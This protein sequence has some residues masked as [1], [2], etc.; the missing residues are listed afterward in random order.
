MPAG[1]ARTPQRRIVEFGCPFRVKR[2]FGNW[3]RRARDFDLELRGIRVGV[4]Q[5]PYWDD[6]RTAVLTSKPSRSAESLVQLLRPILV[7]KS[8]TH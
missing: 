1:S 8:A 7:A 4:R 3:T 6:F 2:R 5:G